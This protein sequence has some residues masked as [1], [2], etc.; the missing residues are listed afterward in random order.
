MP[1]YAARTNPTTLNDRAVPVGTA[2]AR[3]GPS[4]GGGAPTVYYRNQ[5]WDD[6]KVG[7]VPWVTVGGYDLTG[8][9]YPGP[10]AWGVNTS[11]YMGRGFYS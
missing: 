7:Y 4:S 1:T 10:G 11:F 8:A 9:S 5:A 6:V 2:P 3:G